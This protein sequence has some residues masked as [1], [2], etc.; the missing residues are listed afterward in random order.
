[1]PVIC[2]NVRY[3]HRAVFD[4]LPTCSPSNKKSAGDVQHPTLTLKERV[5]PLLRVRTLERLCKVHVREYKPRTTGGQD[6]GT[7]D[8]VICRQQTAA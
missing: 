7:E 4:I 2:L 3:K 6:D 5:V 8:N 1:M